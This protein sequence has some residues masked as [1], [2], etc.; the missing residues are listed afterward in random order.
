MSAQFNE[1]GDKVVTACLDGTAKIW[2][3]DNG[4]LSIPGHKEIAF[5]AYFDRQDNVVTVSTDKTVK[6]WRQR[7]LPLKQLIIL[8]GATIF[9]KSTRE[10]IFSKAKKIAVEKKIPFTEALVGILNSYQTYPK[11]NNV[12]S[13]CSL[14]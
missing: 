11:D 12:I 6:I 4:E 13:S 9:L 1:R 2:Q 14:S 7:V 5:T 3:L 10:E 8:Y